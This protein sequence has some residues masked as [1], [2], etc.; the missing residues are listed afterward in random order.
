MSTTAMFGSAIMV[1]LGWNYFFHSTSF[2]RTTYRIPP[3]YLP[4]QGTFAEAKGRPLA[5]PKPPHISVALFPPAWRQ[6]APIW[7]QVN[8][9]APGS[10]R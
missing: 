2:F 4:T 10:S 1:E 3:M 8:P 9:A 5:G 6:S 7:T